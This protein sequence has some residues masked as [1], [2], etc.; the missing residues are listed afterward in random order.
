MNATNTCS[1]L[2]LRQYHGGDVDHPHSGWSERSLQGYVGTT[3]TLTLEFKSCRALLATD[4]KDRQQRVLAAATDVAAMA[5][6]QGGVIIYGI[7]ESKGGG[8]REALRVEEGFRRDDGVNR[9]WFLQ[10]IRGHIQPPLGE[11]DAVDVPLEGGGYALVVLVPQAFGSA[12]QTSDRLYWRR[13]A[14]GNRKMSHQEI[15]DVRARAYQPVLELEG[16]DAT[17]GS[18]SSGGMTTWQPY[19]QFA[20]SNTSSATASFAVVTVALG[21]GV[22]VTLPSSPQWLRVEMSDTWKVLR[23]VIAS[24]SSPLWSPMTPGFTLFLQQLQVSFPSRETDLG[25]VRPLGLAKLEYDGGSR[26]Y[27]IEYHRSG[28]E[29][30]RIRLTP[31]VTDL[32]PELLN[33]MPIPRVFRPS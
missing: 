28:A 20:I 9:E 10:I 12:R 7:E 11:L 27:R 13:D 32:T 29:Q 24:G 33:G 22:G 6:E 3:E 8:H 4:G 19:V 26:L 5:N 14:H 30:Q 25:R 21:N 17:M 1:A 18:H 31:D 16:Y 23:S 15:E 2:P